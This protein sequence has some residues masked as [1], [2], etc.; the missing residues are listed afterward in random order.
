MPATPINALPYPANTDRVADGATAI[1]ALADQVEAKMVT[2]NARFPS[3]Q[4]ANFLSVTF[5]TGW[6]IGSESLDLRSAVLPGVGR[7]V[8]FCAH[9]TRA[10][11]AATITTSTVGNAADTDILQLPTGFRPVTLWPVIIQVIS[12][13]PAT[14]RI[15]TDGMLIY[16]EQAPGSNVTAG[17]LLRVTATYLA[18]A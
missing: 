5:Q 8:S 6:T 12:K 1:K 13:A 18:A 16:Q 2:S 10:A 4:S 9:F 15:G 17:D 3:L 14:G 7:L 11:G